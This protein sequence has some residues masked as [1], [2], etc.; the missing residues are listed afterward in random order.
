[1]NQQTMNNPFAIGDIVHLPQGTTLYKILNNDKRFLYDRPMPSK[2]VER[3][4]IGLIIKK[5]IN[6]FYMVSIENQEYLIKMQD[7]YYI[8]GETNVYKT[9]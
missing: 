2:I 7:A 3:P 1:M 4:S 6:D 5:V 9:T 8:Y